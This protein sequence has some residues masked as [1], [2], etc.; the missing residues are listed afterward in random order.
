[1]SRDM[2]P[3]V[4][5]THI[6]PLITAALNTDG[7]ILE[8][9]CGDYSTPLLHAICKSQKR[10]LLSTDTDKEWLEKFKDLETYW[11]RFQYVP[12]Y[13][14]NPPN[15]DAWNEVGKLPWLWGLLFVDHRP[16]ERRVQDI[17][18]FK[19]SAW[20]IVVHDT[21]TLSYGYEPAFKLFKYRYDYKR[22]NV[23]TTIVSQFVDVSTWFDEK[24]SRQF[25]LAKAE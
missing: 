9:G 15:S 19:E 20:V 8:L 21:E 2:S 13:E 14:S 7:H 11:H 17:L 10:D 24:N 16:G 5:G 22:Y 12:V 3:S 25:S 18:R 23:H 4:Y 1:M 6:H